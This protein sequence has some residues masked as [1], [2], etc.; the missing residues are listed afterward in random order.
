[1]LRNNKVIICLVLYCCL[2]KI[3]I[4]FDNYLIRLEYYLIIIKGKIG[5]KIWEKNMCK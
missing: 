5:N 2:R 3:L 1:M 4:Y